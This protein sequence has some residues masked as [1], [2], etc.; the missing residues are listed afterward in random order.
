MKL[1]YL[2]ARNVLSFGDEE[3]SLEFGPFNVVAGPNNSGKTNLFRALNLIEQAFDNWNKPPLDEIMFQGDTDRP[4]ILEIGMELNVVQLELIAKSIICSEMVSVGR[5]DQITGDIGKN[6]EWK[7]ILK[8]YGYPILLK[9]LKN[10]SFV[11][12]KDQLRTSEPKMAI[13]IADGDGLYIDRQSQLSQTMQDMRAPQ[14]ISLTKAIIEDFTSRFGNPSE[15][16]F[17]S[18]IQNSNKLLEKSPTLSELLN[19]KLQGVPPKTVPLGRVD[20]N[21]VF[22]FIGT[23][24]FLVDLSLLC[25]REGIKKES[26]YLWGVLG[27]MYKTSFVRLK[28]LRFFPSNAAFSN[29][30]QKSKDILILGS[31]LAK[32]L[33]LLKS[34]GTRKNRW[35]YNRI[36]TEFNDLTKS[37]FD[38]AV[39]AI[40]IDSGTEWKLGATT[41]S[42]SISGSPDFLPLG[43]GRESKK[44][45]ANEAFIQIIK[46][47]YPSTIEQ[48]A[49]GLYEILVLIATIWGESNKILVL[50]EPELHLH[51]AMQRRILNLLFKSRTKEGTQIILATHS[52]YFVSASEIERTWRFTETPKGTK[53]HNISGALSKLEGLDKRKFIAKLSLTDVRSILFSQGVVFVEGLSD[54]L[55]VEQIDRF[56][57]AKEKGANLD[58]NEWPIIDVGGKESLSSFIMLCHVLGVKN[59]A[60]LDYDALMSKNHTIELFSR[61][62]KTSSIFHALQRSGQIEDLQTN[63]DLLSEASNSQWY[64]NSHLDNF[65]TLAASS[66]IFVFSTDLEGAL[67]LPKTADDRKPLRALGR[68][69]ELIN[70]NNIPQEFYDMCIFLRDSMAKLSREST[71][72]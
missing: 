49:S 3:V 32:K 58:E 56:L 67:Q 16:E 46:D 55:V 44:G 37:E 43:I 13:K 33:F 18:L 47:D 52:P 31:D 61:K 57:S 69:I 42:E 19:G 24:P 54:K 53:A 60:V 59:L 11:L 63:A 1:L 20:F 62:V 64:T 51:P 7:N 15:T 71:L 48:T 8:N 36:Q 22:N 25:D 41:R 6:K 12:S 14:S 68:I 28:E 26:L 66:G 50:D 70:Q 39:R 27:Q 65:R 40:E 5:P 29:P 72:A 30:D 4:L 45:L 23:E 34:S 38:V 21:E 10:L 2:K 9:S 17:N 35:R